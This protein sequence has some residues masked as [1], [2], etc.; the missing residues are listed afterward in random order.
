MLKT[1]ELNGTVL[2]LRLLTT[3]S[4]S[5]ISTR[6]WLQN[7]KLRRLLRWRNIELEQHGQEIL[8]F[9]IVLDHSM[10]K[11]EVFKKIIYFVET[12]L[13]NINNIFEM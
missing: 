7:Q 2:F 12:Y 8:E 3:L 13:S 9:M 11:Q 5:G 4:V 10:K 6:Q 1:D